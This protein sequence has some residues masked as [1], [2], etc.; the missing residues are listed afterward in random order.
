MPRIEARFEPLYQQYR[1]LE[2]FEVTIHPDEQTLMETLPSVWS[3]LKQTITDTEQ[4]IKVKKVLLSLPF[5]SMYQFLIQERFKS[6]LMKSTNEFS[7]IVGSVRED[8]LSK[9]PFTTQFSVDEAR[10]IIN[11]YLL[12]LEDKLNFFD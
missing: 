5:E 6:D 2:K 10:N 3:S 4:M 9:G 1:S 11:E 8:F 12:C 7:T